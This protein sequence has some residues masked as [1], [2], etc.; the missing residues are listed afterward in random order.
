MKRNIGDT[1]IIGGGVIGL[2]LAAE[3]RL[4]GQDVT[5]LSRKP[6]EAAAL[7]A[8]GMLAPE[9]E[10]LPEGPLLSLGLRSRALYPEWIGKLERLT[11]LSAGYWPCGI[12]APVFE[13]PDVRLNQEN[14]L[15]GEA[16]R[17]FQPGLGPEVVGAWWRPED[18]QVDN[19]RLMTVLHRAAER[20]GVN[21]QAG[22]AVTA[23]SLRGEILEGV[24]T[25]AGMFLAQNYVLASG[26]WASELLPL[27]VFPV[28]GEMLSLQMP[29]QAN[30]AFPLERVLFG[31]GTYLAPR[32][33]GRLIIG[34]TVEVGNWSAYNTPQGVQTLLER[35]TRLYPGLACWPLQEIWWG[36]RPGTLDEG[37]LLGPGPW[38]NLTLATG[39]YRNGVLLAPVTARLLADWLTA[40]QSDPLLEAFSYRRFEE[41]L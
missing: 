40:G 30:G 12:L 17:A 27:P 22:V 29:P 39:H 33:D 34:A 20:L 2:A 23:L 18:G 3:L 16:L 10:Q 6:Q 5:V 21:V 26:A 14:W 32:R 13:T 31:P 35:A 36:F 7:A 11:N 19:R 28:K 38:E 25:D 15:E 37:P 4:R 41:S 9:A 8:A 24:E 1:V